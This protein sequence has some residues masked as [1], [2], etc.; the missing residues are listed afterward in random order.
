MQLTMVTSSKTKEITF[1]N[2]PDVA[3]ASVV[4]S[5]KKLQ[6]DRVETRFPKTVYYYSNSCIVTVTQILD[7]EIH[8]EVTHL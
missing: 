2:H 5:C 7:T 3:K 4:L 6:L 1:F 8:S